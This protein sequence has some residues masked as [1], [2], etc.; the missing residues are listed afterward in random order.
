MRSEAMTERIYLDWNATAPLREEAR[1]AAAAALGVCGNPSSVHGEGRAARRLVEQAREAVAGLMGAESRNLTFTSGGTEANVLA[2]S[3]HLAAPAEA[4]CDCLLVSAIEHPSVLAG[5]RFPR[6]AVETVPVTSD[7]EVDLAALRRQLSALAEQ[8]RRPLVSLMLANNETG[9]IQPVAEAAALAHAA[10][11]LLHVDA[12]QALGRIPFDVNS[13]NAD[14]LTVSGHKIGA[15]KGVGALVKR[16]H[17]LNAEPLIKGG[18]QERG[19]RGGTENVAGIAGFGAAAAAARAA[20]AVEGT[21]MAAL[22][23]RLEA[24]LKARMPAAIVF[25]AAA[26]RLPNT[27]L[28]AVPGIKAETAVIALDLAG[29]AVSSGAACSSGK[30][31]PSHVLAAMGVAPALAQGAIRASLGP[32]TTESEVD[33]FLDAWIRLAEPLLKGRQGIAA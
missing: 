7:G 19:A 16:D 26:T 22:R 6:E 33:C 25:G 20:S 4:P 10:G 8:G 23:A 15:P 30:V 9:V 29:F 2:L 27:T 32:S 24:G 3:P 12:V 13:L 11:A 18:G 17:A 5:G 31:Q 21:H 14:L 28:F 1:A